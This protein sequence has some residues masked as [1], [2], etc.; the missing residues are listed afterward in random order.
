MKLKAMVMM[1]VLLA[2]CQAP[3]L[4]Q[5]EQALLQTD[6][7][8]AEDVAEGR[9]EAWTS[10]FASDGMMLGEDGWVT[11]QSA[12]MDY[13]RAVFADESV[14]LTWTPQVAKVAYYGDMGYTIG[15]YEVVQGDPEGDFVRSNGTYVTIW[16]KQ[17][18]GSWKVAVDIG[19]P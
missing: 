1:A 16:R 13:A 6:V 8:F 18:D 12:I 10:Y 15:T 14:E 5:E 9:A 17:D 3:N 2:A 11:G 19:N 7:A 4:E